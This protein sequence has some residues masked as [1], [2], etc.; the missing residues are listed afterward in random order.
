MTGHQEN[1]G[2]GFKLQGEASTVVDIEA[3]VKAVGVRH[4]R[5]LNPLKLKECD[6][7]LEW[8]KGVVT[9]SREPV[10]LITRWPCILK[11]YSEADKAEFGQEAMKCEVVEASCIGCK[12]CVKT[13]CPA[14]IFDSAAKKARIDALQCV[15][16]GVC[17]Q[18]C[19]KHAIITKA[20]V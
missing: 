8:A 17:A 19:P 7:A 18:V 3:L 5:T 13:G 4:V 12:A 2:S 9:G 6:E 15:G 14:I 20:G 16:C 10:V 1:P 11:K